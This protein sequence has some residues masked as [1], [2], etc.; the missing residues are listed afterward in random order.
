MSQMDERRGGDGSPG[1]DTR[2][3]RERGVL[4]EEMRAAAQARL[5]QLGVPYREVAERVGINLSEVSRLMGGERSLTVQEAVRLAE[6]L[7][8]HPAELLPGG[9]PLPEVVPQY[10]VWRW[11]SC[12]DPR[13]RDGADDP[14]H[15][16]PA[17]WGARDKLGKNGFGVMV[18]G[19]SMRGRDIHPY[20]TVWV[21]PDE[22]PRVNRV[23][24]ARAWDEHDEELGMVV[25]V[26]GMDEERGSEV[27][28]SVR[29]SRD[30]QVQR[31]EVYR[32][33]ARMDVIGPVVWVTSGRPPGG[34][35]EERG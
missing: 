30:G 2:K 10:P 7:E 1:G 22:A 27:L 8:W 25:K 17:P 19:E 5:G 31:P 6:V 3:R 35:R 11:G 9:P 24:L 26:L 13:D 34:P 12:G 29:V 16:E 20:D 18:Q 14:D 4:P 21:N 15:E 28:K 32:D 33:C 23:V